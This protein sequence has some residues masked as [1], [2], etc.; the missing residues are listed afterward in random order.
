MEKYMARSRKA[1]SRLT[2]HCS[3][4]QD[5]RPWAMLVFGAIF[6]YSSL[7]IDPQ[8]NCSADGECAPWLV[9]IAFAIGAGVGLAGLG[10]LLANP[11]RGCHIDANG[12]LV[13]WQ[14]RYGQS[15]GDGGAIDPAEISR[16]R[17]DRRRESADEVHLYNRG[18]E[19]QFYF[20]DEVIGW[21]KIG[22]A[23]AMR[24][25]FPHTIVE[26]LD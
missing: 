6:L 16:I 8:T 19:R 12:T 20:D 2:F 22:W 11:N 25:R 17:I 15:G 26:V 3:A 7:I 9:P 18:G 10:W 5:F 1:K 21:D 24:E 4:R 13:W 23:E 14:N